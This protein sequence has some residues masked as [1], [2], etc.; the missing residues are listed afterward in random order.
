[1]IGNIDQTMK[2]LENDVID[3]HSDSDES[4]KLIERQKT[5]LYFL[6]QKRK[7]RKDKVVKSN[8]IEDRKRGL[9]ANVQ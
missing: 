7:E 2:N 3:C 5:R 1:M 9:D 8:M 4:E 6:K